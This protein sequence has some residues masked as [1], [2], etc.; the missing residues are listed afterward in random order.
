MIPAFP[1]PSQVKKPPVAVKVF[2]DGRE[3]CNLLCRAGADEY[4]RRKRVAWEEQGHRCSIGGEPLQDPRAADCQRRSLT[5]GRGV[6]RSGGT[7][8]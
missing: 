5:F 3:V 6:S 7:A 1:K 2:R 4:Q 8:G